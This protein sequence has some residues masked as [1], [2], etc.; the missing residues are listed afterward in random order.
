MSAIITETAGPAFTTAFEANFADFFTTFG[1]APGG[2][3][4]HDDDSTSFISGLP[5]DLVNGVVRTD[6]ADGLSPAM[7]RERAAAVLAR[8]QARAVP[9]LWWLPPSTRPTDLGAHLVALGLRP[10]GAVPGMVA[11]LLNLADSLPDPADLTI[12]EVTDAAMLRAWVDTF[13]IGYEL[14][15]LVT[16]PFF[17]SLERR[18]L[19]ADRPLR[20]FLARL[21]GEPVATSSLL[22]SAGVASLNAVATV[23]AAR[24]QG[25]GAAISAAPMRVARALGYRVGI[26]QASHLGRPVYQRLGFRDCFPLPIYAWTP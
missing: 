4:H 13:T 1:L 14:P 5:I 2:E 19:G 7:L 22:L 16:E 24:R 12:E 3:V 15:D 9:L 18:G 21:R 8:F 23:P 25:V 20:H 6:F 10:A 26:L 17:A 11:D